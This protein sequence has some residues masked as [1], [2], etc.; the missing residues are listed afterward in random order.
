[1]PALDRIGTNQVPLKLALGQIL[2]VEVV[3]QSRDLLLM[4]SNQAIGFS[5][6]NKSLPAWE[7]L[8]VVGV[9]LVICL[10]CWCNGPGPEQGACTAQAGNGTCAPWRT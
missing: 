6:R 10:K 9:S 4:V 8:R 7:A 5:I 1:M 2:W 3:V